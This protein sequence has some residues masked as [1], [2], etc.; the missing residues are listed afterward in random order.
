M[1]DY[2]EGRYTAKI[3]E[4]TIVLETAGFGIQIHILPQVWST[5]PQAGAEKKLRI[6]LSMHLSDKDPLQFYGF[7]SRITRDFFNRLKSISGFGPKTALSLLARYPLAELAHITEKGDAKPLL[8]IKGIGGKIAE[9]LLVELK[10]IIK[11]MSI[12]GAKPGEGGKKK[13]FEKKLL[14]DVHEILASLGYL[15]KE[16]SWVFSVLSDKLKKGQW[17]ID[18]I[19]AAALDEFGKKRERS[20]TKRTR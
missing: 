3:A 5:L 18:K 7:D 17:T 16:I 11:K 4:N 2:I 13:S 12:D 14:D 9:R 20:K 10:N 15:E 8:Q 19:V 1:I 6:Y